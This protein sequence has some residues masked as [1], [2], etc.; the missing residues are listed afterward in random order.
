MPT[1]D[2]EIYSKLYSYAPL[3]YYLNN[4]PVWPIEFSKPFRLLLAYAPLTVQ[5]FIWT[6]PVT[7]LKFV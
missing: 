7:L 6:N 3:H 5:Y 4:F 2:F 1:T